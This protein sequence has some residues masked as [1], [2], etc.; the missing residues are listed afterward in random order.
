MLK[1]KKH[2]FASIADTV[3][4]LT[5]I[6]AGMS[7]KDRRIVSIS[8]TPDD[9]FYIRVY[10][11][12]EQFVDVNSFVLTVENPFLLM[13]LPLAEGQ[14]CKAGFQN[15]TGDTVTDRDITIGYTEAG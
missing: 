2:R 4:D 7:G 15:S 9:A 14:L 6:L 1:Y 13:D 10:R 8:A 11:D 12:A 3:E 5:D